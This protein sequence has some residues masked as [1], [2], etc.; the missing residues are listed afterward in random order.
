MLPKAISNLWRVAPA[1]ALL[2]LFS[3]SCKQSPSM[4]KPGPPFVAAEKVPPGNALVYIYWPRDDQDR[5]KILWAGPCDG[6]KEE[7]QPGAY[8]AFAVKPGP[9][10]FNVEAHSKLVYNEPSAISTIYPGMELNAVQGRTF[11][12]RLERERI[13]PRF[14]LRPVQPVLGEPE[15]RQCQKLIPLT[16]DEIF[17]QWQEDHADE[18]RAARRK[19]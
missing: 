13:L 2:S 15:I 16:D 12:L 8:T 3:G 14:V 7:L 1:L 6:R 17:Q 19:R 10:C 5:K 9:K 11:F 4:T 18:I